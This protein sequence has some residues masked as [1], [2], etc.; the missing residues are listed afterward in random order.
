MVAPVGSPPVF[1]VRTA[2][3]SGSVPVIVNETGI[4]TGTLSGPDSE[5]SHSGAVPL[6]PCTMN[7]RKSTGVWDLTTPPG[8]RSSTMIWAVHGLV[9]LS[10]TVFQV[11][12]PVVA[13]T[14]NPAGAATPASPAVATR[15]LSVSLSKS[16]AGTTKVLAGDSD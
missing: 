11:T 8:P 7:I 4:P 1:K 5:M 13:S 15:N 2:P 3:T 6:R 16:T 9:W 14:V 12:T 10:P